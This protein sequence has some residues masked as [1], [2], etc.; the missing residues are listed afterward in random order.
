M[1]KKDNIIACFQRQQQFLFITT[2]LP[3]ED[4]NKTWPRGSP[5][6]YTVLAAFVLT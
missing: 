2:V 6:E 3:H 4:Q 5:D 1:V